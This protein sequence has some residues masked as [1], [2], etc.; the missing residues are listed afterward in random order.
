MSQRAEHHYVPVLK[1]KAGEFGALGSLLPT[2]KD[3][4]TPLI[5]VFSVPFDWTAGRDA[6]TLDEHLRSTVAG[7]ADTWG[8][9]RSVWLDM[10]WHEPDA[11]IAGT[12]AVEHLHRLSRTSLLAVPVGGP[13]R[14][15]THTASVAAVAAADGRGAV[16]RLDPEDLETFDR[17]A[18]Q[19]DAWLAVVMLRPEDVDLVVD[20]GAV[21]PALASAVALGVAAVLPSLPHL[22]RWRTLTLVS[23]AFPEDLSAVDSGVTGRL[24]RADWRLWRSVTARPLARPP[25]FGDYT[26]GHPALF[27]PDPR[28]IKFGATIR[29]SGPDDWVV[30]KGRGVNKHGFGQFNGGSATVMALPEWDWP[31]HCA[32][33]DFIAACAGGGQ[34]GNLQTWRRV[35]TTHHLTLTA[36]QLASLP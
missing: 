15:P 29:F 1:G 4:V 9:D 2:V 13:G 24:A 32:G 12:S 8:S 22:Q 31:G 19:I 35:A 7:V 6:K 10:L 18:P 23:G 36:G 33:C 28:K 5:E 20:L 26:V 3:R 34:P 16:L 14:P 21:S 27:D 11:A 17:L 25:A 30:V